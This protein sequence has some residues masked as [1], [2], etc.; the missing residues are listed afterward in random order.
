MRHLLS[1]LTIGIFLCAG[2][3]LSAAEDDKS[4]STKT[5]KAKEHTMEGTWIWAR[6]KK[7]ENGPIKAVFT[8]TAKKNEYVAK[9]YFDFRKKPYVYTGTASGDL[10]NGAFKGAVNDGNQKK[11]RTFEFSGNNKA[12][13]F[14]GDHKETTKGS[15]QTG[16]ITWKPKAAAKTP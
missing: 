7:N 4:G 6:G 15:K 8:E 10:K 16:T 2:A 14:S 3:T 5:A 13:A 11:L 9:F 1:L 12:G